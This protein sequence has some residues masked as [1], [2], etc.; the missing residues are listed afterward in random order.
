MMFKGVPFIFT[1]NKLPTVMKE[2][3]KKKDEDD[4]D[5]RERYNNYMA[6]KTRCKTHHMNRSFR[7]TDRFP[8]N[9]EEL[10]IYMNYVCDKIQN[11]GQNE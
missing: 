4:W 11:V 9:T 8:Y 5:F 2:P 7:N 1:T 6:F 10:A 3:K